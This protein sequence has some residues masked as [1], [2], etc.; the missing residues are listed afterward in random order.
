[1]STDATK[2]KYVVLI[3]ILKDDLRTTSGRLKCQKCEDEFDD[4]KSLDRHI[5]EH[6]LK[7]KTTTNVVKPKCRSVKSSP[8]YESEGC[9]EAN[10][11]NDLEF[12]TELENFFEQQNSQVNT[13]CASIH[14]LL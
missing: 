12:E 11:E 1:M 7:R 10:F 4:V 2:K 6:R 8:V 14:K 3:N 5:N 9:E 13:K